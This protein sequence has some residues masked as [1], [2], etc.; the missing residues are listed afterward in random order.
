[1]PADEMFDGFH[2]DRHTIDELEALAAER[3]GQ[4][5]APYFDELR[6]RTAHWSPGQFRAAEEAG[7]ETERRLLTLMHN[8]AA[9]DDPAVFEVL[10]D[11]VAAQR[12]L[13]PLTAREYGQLGQA[14][15]A[16]PELRAHL[17]ARDPHLAEYMR[18]AMVA[19]A[20]SR[21]T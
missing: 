1:M 9:P 12:R 5:T 7:T 15:A 2:F 21:M 20:S 13:M 4:E 16:A 3:P 11:D 10:D 18:D 19:Y 6:R 14:F 17:D 8:G